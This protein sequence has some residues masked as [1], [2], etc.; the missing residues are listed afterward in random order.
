M[1]KNG[2]PIV[3]FELNLISQN[4][5]HKFGTKYNTKDFYQHIYLFIYSN[6]LIIGKMYDKEIFFRL[7][8]FIFILHMQTD[9]IYSV[10]L[11]KIMTPPVW[12]TRKAVTP[13]LSIASLFMTPP[14]THTPLCRHPLEI[15][16]DRS[17]III[18][19]ELSIDPNAKT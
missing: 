8:I 4:R 15:N 9:F 18:L 1:Y 12:S 7:N 14:H 3:I 10:C 6:S 19:P 16:N 5:I 2:F 11:K 13:P 17:L